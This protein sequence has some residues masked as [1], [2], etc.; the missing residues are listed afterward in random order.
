MNTIDGS[1]PQQRDLE[2]VLAKL[3]SL[4]IRGEFSNH[5]LE[6]TDLDDVRFW[7][8]ETTAERVAKAT[9]AWLDLDSW[10]ERCSFLSQD[11]GGMVP[12]NCDFSYI[13]KDVWIDKDRDHEGVLLLHPLEEKKPAVITYQ[14]EGPIIENSRVRIVSRSTNIHPGVIM[15]VFHKRKEI[16]SQ[17]VDADWIPVHGTL[18]E[19][20]SKKTEITIE[21]WAHQWNNELCYID[22]I[23]IVPP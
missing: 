2:R 19:G 12:A 3:D 15:K 8:A 11:T 7:N 22:S 18:Q 10:R 9:P 16:A 6:T 13:G 4:K 20:G 5:V 17:A 1:P 21:V 23:E 14:V